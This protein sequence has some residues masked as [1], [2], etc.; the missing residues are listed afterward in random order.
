MDSLQV[1]KES[2]LAQIS[3]DSLPKIYFLRHQVSV[4]FFFPTFGIFKEG[5]EQIQRISY[6]DIDWNSPN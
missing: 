3:K 2:T 4:L 1:F 5:S 6:T